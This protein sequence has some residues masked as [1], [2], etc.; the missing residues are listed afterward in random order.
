MFMQDEGVTWIV[1]ADGAEAKVFEERLKAGAVHELPD[2]RM[3]Q[4]GGDF[5]KATSHGATVHES[6]GPGRHQSGEH[7]PRQEAEDRFLRRVAEALGQAASRNTYQH[8]VLMAPPRALGALR[9]ALPKPAHDRLAGS[10][11]HECVRE[12]ADQIRERLRAVRA[13]S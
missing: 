6:G 5:P 11:A 8:L 3:S 12:G 10:D 4:S 2:W 7:A 9:S 1:A 13:R